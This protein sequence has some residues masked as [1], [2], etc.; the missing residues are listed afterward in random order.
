MKTDKAILNPSNFDINSKDILCSPYILYPSIHVK[1]NNKQLG[2][3]T[4]NNTKI[5]LKKKSI[6]IMEAKFSVPLKLGSLDLIEKEIDKN[7]DYK[8]TI[9][10]VLCNLINKIKFYKDLVVNE[11]LSK[12]DN[13]KNYS[14]RLL[15]I[16]DNKPVKEFSSQ[17]IEILKELHGKNLI[18]YHNFEIIPIYIGPNLGYVNYRVVSNEVDNLKKDLISTAAR[19]DCKIQF[20]EN[21][22]DKMNRNIEEMKNERDQMKERE[23]ELKKRLIHLEEMLSLIINKNGTLPHTEAKNESSK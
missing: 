4:S 5:V 22:I 17:I 3:D 8:K 11:F 19:L 15:L 9:Y 23:N 18:N 12:D 20:L 2:I 6:N 1:K 21:K 7:K 16:F 14:F 10:Y 13:I